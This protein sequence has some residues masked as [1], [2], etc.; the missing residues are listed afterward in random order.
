MTDS[1]LHQ[2]L[3]TLRQEI[4]RLENID[5]ASRQRLEGLITSIEHNSEQVQDTDHHLRLIERIRDEAAFFEAS[6]PQLALALNEIATT[7][8]NMGI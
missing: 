5:A 2:A 1:Q 7:L 8:S 6:H 3:E 4:D